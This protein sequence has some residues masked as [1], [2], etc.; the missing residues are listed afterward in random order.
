MSLQDK[1]V[2]VTGAA[3]GIGHAPP[4]RSLPRAL[5]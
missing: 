3:S 4:R 1:I 2:V 5:A